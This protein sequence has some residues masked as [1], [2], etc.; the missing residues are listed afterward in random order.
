LTKFCKGFKLSE[1]TRARLLRESKAAWENEG[2]T[3]AGQGS[4][5]NDADYILST[6]PVDQA[7]DVIPIVYDDVIRSSRFLRTLSNVRLKP[8]TEYSF[9]QE[10][11]LAS[12]GRKTFQKGAI[13]GWQSWDVQQ[14]IIVLRGNVQ[15][16][17]QFVSRSEGDLVER[18]TKVWKEN[19]IK[20]SVLGNISIFADGLSGQLSPDTISTLIGDNN[21]DKTRWLY[22]VR[23]VSDECE[24]L[25]FDPDVMKSL[26]AE[27][28]L[29]ETLMRTSDE[30]L[31]SITQ[32][33]QQQ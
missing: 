22:T 8:E 25:F 30:Y 1:E 23:C 13:L 2:R 19:V 11:L 28:G 33:L 12:S 10:F 16:Q 9:T 15:L 18:K 32:L 21:N 29:T 31:Q 5:S 4:T 17:I 6:L 26:A 24:V 14:G 20:G 3:F 27:Y 7:R